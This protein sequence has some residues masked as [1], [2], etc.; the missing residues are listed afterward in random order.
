MDGLLIVDKPT[1][2]TSHDVVSRARRVLREK[3][4]GHTGTLDP[5]A[6]GVLPLVVGRATR[7]ARFLSGDKAYDATV[8][9][10]V[11]TDTY[12]AMGQPTGVPFTGRWPST[13][14][15][16]AALARFRGTFSQQ[17]PAYSAKKIAGQRSYALARKTRTASSAGAV[18]G[19]DT[20]T[21]AQPPL[22]SPVP[23]TAYTV[24]VL[25]V[26]G[27]RVRLHVRCSAGF[28]IRSLAFDLGA[29]L[30][31]G[32]HLVELRRTE[33]AG[34]GLSE[35]LPL[36][37]LMAEDGAQRAADRLVPMERMLK[38]LPAVSLTDDGVAHV[39]FGR[40]LGPAA[41]R[42]GFLSA[43]D[44]VTGAAPSP[45]RLLAPSG[46][47][48]AVADAADVPGLLHPAVVLL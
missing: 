47:L 19:A 29:S 38:A 9:L 14:E 11:D 31:T 10:G 42:A 18:D 21:D 22:P 30:G 4:I 32:A 13:A 17:P 35:A 1:G 37:Q 20:E 5:M 40:N 39:R 23:V 8:C 27:P 34:F 44:A 41:A 7:L 15:I 2:P 24:E 33:A 46:A 48:V 6:S 28:Y 43:L 25:E 26:D 16:H 45:V 36:D 3:R 12:D